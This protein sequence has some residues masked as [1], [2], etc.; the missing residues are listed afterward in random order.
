MIERRIPSDR[1]PV[2][3]PQ[4][5]EVRDRELQNIG[6]QFERDSTAGAVFP[7]TL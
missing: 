7:A 6:A 4:R 3:L 2:D 1:T 5:P